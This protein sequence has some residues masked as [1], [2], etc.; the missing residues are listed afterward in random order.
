[1]AKPKSQTIQQRLGFMDEDLKTTK[2]DEIMLWLDSAIENHFELLM[3]I[4]PEWQPDEIHVLD[5]HS[6]IKGEEKKFILLENSSIFQNL[7]TKT[8]ASC[9][10]K[11]WE[12][13]ILNN[14]FIVGF[15]DLK[16][17]CTKPVLEF[18]KGKLEVTKEFDTIFFEIKSEIKSLG[19]L[20]RQIRMYQTYTKGKW[21]VVSPDAKFSSQLEKQGIG[22]I[23]YEPNRFEP[24]EVTCQDGTIIEKPIF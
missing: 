24:D 4:L 6:E 22:F 11:I 16:V 19:E 5:E 23:K 13:P 1:M 2:H 17:D 18:Y 14:K 9:K 20:I 7:P 15:V 10:N 12:F 3:K 8:S 21:F